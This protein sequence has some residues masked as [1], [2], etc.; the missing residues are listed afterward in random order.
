MWFTVQYDIL[1]RNCL[2]FLLWVGH[3]ICNIITLVGYNS[4]ICRVSALLKITTEK[5]FL[6]NFS[7]SAQ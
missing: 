3:F 7:I 4:C 1:Y 5:F 6:V 2:D